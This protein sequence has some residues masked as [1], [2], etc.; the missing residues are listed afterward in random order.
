MLRFFSIF[1]LMFMICFGVK[2]ADISID[3]QVEF[4]QFHMPVEQKLTSISLKNLNI[5]EQFWEKWN[6]FSFD[7]NSLN[8]LS[9]DSCRFEEGA[10]FE[11]LIEFKPRTL[12]I[13]NCEISDE[14]LFSIMRYSDPY[15]TKMILSGNSLG[16]DSELF[17][18]A[19]GELASK[20]GDY[21]N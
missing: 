8:D 20:G 5:N 18:R 6:S 16:K 2:A 17:Q 1:V 11:F 7:V 19:L 12:K 21:Q 9:F 10:G 13:T 15:I 3:G 14:N 4:E